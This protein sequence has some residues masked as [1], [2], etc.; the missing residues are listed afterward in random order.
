MRRTF[1]VDGHDRTSEDRCDYLAEAFCR[2]PGAYWYPAMDGGV[3]V[4]CEEHG[5]KHFPIGAQRIGDLTWHGGGE[6]I[7]RVAAAEA[8]RA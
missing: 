1:I 5:A 4:L 7:A 8:T 3:A 6:P 2:A